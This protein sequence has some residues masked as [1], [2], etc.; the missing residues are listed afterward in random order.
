MEPELTGEMERVLERYA[1]L[2]EREREIGQEKS[3]LQRKLWEHVAPTGV[4][5][6]CVEVAGV[7]RKVT[8]WTRTTVE[9]DEKLL[10]ARL[11]DRYAGLL[12][13]DPGKIR[14]H[15]GEV[16]SLLE[17]VIETVGSVDR[18][19]VRAAIEAG[20]ASAEE[21]RGAC[22]RTERTVVSVARVRKQGYAFR[23]ERV[24]R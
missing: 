8:C 20:E 11:G 1:A 16:A 15:A 19:K 3:L 24:P 22:T 23:G 2:Q 18:E 10:R 6:W 5:V 14:R 9:Y 13:P 7:K 17:P 4:K 21:F 12:S